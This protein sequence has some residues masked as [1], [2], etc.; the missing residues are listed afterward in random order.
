MTKAELIQAATKRTN[1]ARVLGHVIDYMVEVGKLSPPPTF[2][3]S[4]R[5]IYHTDHIEQVIAH[6]T[7]KQVTS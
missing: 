1:G 3:G 2:D 5:R 6:V 4:H 7:R